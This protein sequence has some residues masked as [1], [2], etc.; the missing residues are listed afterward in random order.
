[1]QTATS[2]KITSEHV[3]NFQTRRVLINGQCLHSDDQKSATSTRVVEC[4]SGYRSVSG[5]DL[6]SMILWIRI[7]NGI[8]IPDPVYFGL[9]ILLPIKIQLLEI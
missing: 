1:L 2:T 3:K 8:Q 6:D 5:L 4:R 9:R 7:R